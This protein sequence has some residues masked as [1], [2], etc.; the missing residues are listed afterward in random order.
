MVRSR[1]QK[2]EEKTGKRKQEKETGGVREELAYPFPFGGFEDH[3]DGRG[4]GH[5]GCQETPR[6]DAHEP[7]DS[8][9]YLYGVH[10]AL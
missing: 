3:P 6:G 2:Q 1:T 9:G 7:Q 10:R 4:G 8:S 5:R